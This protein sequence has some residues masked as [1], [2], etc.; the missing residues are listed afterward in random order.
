MMQ[1]WLQNSF[2]VQNIY[3]ICAKVNSDEEAEQNEWGFSSN[4]SND[5]K[6][7]VTK[8]DNLANFGTICTQSPSIRGVQLFKG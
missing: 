3:F 7:K 5:L 2:I 6:I 1:L 4:S 8:M